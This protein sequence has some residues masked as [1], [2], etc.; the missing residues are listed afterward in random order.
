MK[1]RTLVRQLALITMIFGISACAGDSCSCDGFVTKDFPVDKADKTIPKSGEVR[2]TESGLSFLSDNLPDIVAGFLPG[3]LNFC[4]PP[5]SVSGVDICSDGSTCAGGGLGCNMTLTIDDADI[6][7]THP[8]T[9]SVTILIGDLNET[10]PLE[11]LGA[12][13]TL[14]LHSEADQDQPATIGGAIPITFTVDTSSP[15]N[16]VRVEIQDAEVDTDDVGYDI[17][18]VSFGDLLVCEGADLI[19]ESDFVRNLLLSQLEDQFIPII[20]EQFDQFLCQPCDEGCPIGSSCNMDQGLCRY[21]DDTCPQ[22]PLGLAGELKLGTVLADYTENPDASVDLTVRAADQAVVD[23]GLTLALRSGYDPVEGSLCI[24]VDP[25]ARKFA[26]LPLSPTVTGNTRPDGTPFHFGLGYHKTAFEELLWSVWGSGATCL[27][28]GTDTVGLVTTGAFG[29]LLPSIKQLAYGK[30]S[31]AY[32]KIVPQTPPKVILGA[33]DVTPMGNSYQIDDPLMTIDWKD[34]DVHIYGYVQDRFT[35]IVTVRM[36]L[37]LPIAVVADG[38]GG[39]IPVLGDFEEALTNERI[40]H[41]GL[42]AEDPERIL[43]LL[44]TLIGFALP[45]LADSLADPIE[46]PEF[47]GFRIHIGPGDVTSVDNNTSIAIFADL[48]LA[49]MPLTLRSDTTIIDQRVDLSRRTP[50]GMVRPTVTLDVLPLANIAQ[51]DQSTGEVEYSYRVDHG[52]WSMFNRTNEL[53]VDHPLLVWPG[54]HRIDV[55]ARYVGEPY[56][57]DPTPASTTVVIDWEPPTV[58]IERRDAIVTFDGSDVVDPQNELQYRY[59]LIT[60]DSP[61]AWTQWSRR[62][63]LDLAGIDTPERF[64]LDVE[65]RDRAGNTGEDTQTITWHRPLERRELPTTNTADTENQPRLGCNAAG[66]EGPAGLAWLLL[67]GGGFLLVRRRRSAQLRVVGLAALLSVGACKCGEDPPVQDDGC[68]PACAENQDCVNGQCITP[69]QCTVDEDCSEHEQCLGGECVPA[70]T[71]EEL[72]DCPAGEFATC[73]NDECACQPYCPDGCEDGQYCCHDSNSCESLP[74][75]CAET[76]CDIGFGPVVQ[77]DASGDSAS[78]EVAPGTCECEKLPPLPLGW[79]GHYADIDRNGGTTAIA[80]YNSTYEDLMVGIIDSNLDI[81]WHFVDGTPDMGDVQGALDGPRGGIADKGEDVGRYTSIAIDD[82]GNIHVFYQDSDRNVLKWARGSAN[83]AQYDFEISD[84]DTNGDTGYWTSAVHLDGT[85]H[86]VYSVKSV[87]DGEGG[88]ASQLRHVSFDAS[89]TPAD[90][91]ATNTEIVAAVSDNPCGFACTVRRNVCF[92]NAGQCAE[93]SGD[94]TQDCA[95]GSACYMGTCEI[96]YKSPAVGYL[97]AAGTNAELSTTP[98]GGLL[99]VYWD[100]SQRSVAWSR[101]DGANWGT[102]ALIGTG[103][104]PW[105]SGMVDAADNVHLAYMEAGEPPQLTYLNISSATPEIIQ[106]G[107]RDT[108]DWWLVNDIGDGVDL[109]V[110]TDGTV[111]AVYQDATQHV[112]KI[113]TRDGSGNWTVSDLATS[114]EPYTGSYGFYAAMLKLPEAQMA[115]ELVIDNQLDP[116]KAAPAIHE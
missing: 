76:V 88:Y 72:C 78:C 59:K 2:V 80:A 64:R 103:T 94:C 28:V 110:A 5:S 101:W 52:T 67:V 15:F 38:M 19:A 82:A 41:A 8:D 115:V 112:L 57:V 92:A 84:L 77:T 13:C 12:D 99:L 26:A 23:T 89:G 55:R 70:P 20:Q 81:T 33:N 1:T 66:G 86:L 73:E 35:R 34:L 107:I 22:N 46:I 9:L 30:T 49:Q 79:H 97:R 31:E 48:E 60:G 27:R 25:T 69:S 116:T 63:Q 62:D 40:L 43:E 42:V 68:D 90:P 104:G 105:A 39:I 24:P 37:L 36:D 50:S 7:A 65:V 114:G 75:P 47:F 61:S 100:H 3:G 83:G 111:T 53:L 85:I 29:A 17:D 113:A 51:L 91:T 108:T 56:T 102:P 32:V 98:D 45:A 16:D 71:C 87:D 14:R 4:V 95:D 93:P 74:D 44:P 18:A 10:L 54:E 21:G 96:V 58:E 109:R 6:V 11:F 106:D